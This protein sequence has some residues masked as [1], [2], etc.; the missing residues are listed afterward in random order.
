MYKVTD[1]IMMLASEAMMNRKDNSDILKKSGVP[2]LFICGKEDETVPLEYALKQ[3]SLPAVSDFHLFSKVKHMS[4][5]E[6]KR[7]TID[8]M[9]GFI[10]RCQ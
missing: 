4:M 6:R 10:Q 7:E 8:A 1:E 2:V 9:R 5:F 3:A